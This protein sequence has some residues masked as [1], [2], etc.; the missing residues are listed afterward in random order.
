MLKS[1]NYFSFSEKL[2]CAVERRKKKEKRFIAIN[3][4]RDL[5]KLVSVKNINYIGT[6]WATKNLLYTVVNSRAYVGD[7]RESNM[8]VETSC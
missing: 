8:E 1:I 3:I 6:T 7:V 5:K 4:D 2:N